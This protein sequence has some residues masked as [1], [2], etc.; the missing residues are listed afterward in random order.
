MKFSFRKVIWKILSLLPSDV[1]FSIIRSGIKIQKEQLSQYRFKIA[2]TQG[3]IEQGF[4]LLYESYLNDGMI[5]PNDSQLRITKFHVL[6][7]STMIVGLKGDEVVATVTHVLDSSF[8]LPCDKVADFSELRKPE[9]T[10][11]EVSALA[12]KK[13][14]RRQNSLLFGLTRF[15]FD[16]SYHQCGVNY[17]VICIRKRIQDYYRAVFFFKPFSKSD[18]NYSEV[19]GL[20]SVILKNELK[21]LP[22]L[23]EN[24]YKSLP[25]EKNL[26]EFYFGANRELEQNVPDFLFKTSTLPVLT[27]SML[28]YF[29][30]EKTSILSELTDSEKIEILNAYNH[31]EYEEVIELETNASHSRRTSPRRTV[32]MRGFFVVPNDFINQIINVSILCISR[33]GLL[34]YSRHGLPELDKI[35]LHVEIV[36]NQTILVRLEFIKEFK[37]GTFACRIVADDNPAWL[38]FIDAIEAHIAGFTANQGAFPV[39]K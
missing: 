24:H 20:E 5:D 7:T 31:P 34:M 13:G 19:K 10:I 39:D 21:T 3:E 9:V 11:A 36:P 37:E 12:I 22:H 35:E 38:K 1:R 15:L 14:Y 8:G 25:D 2:T 32:N 16:Y 18:F 30:N 33:G 4:R 23:F 26:Y 29:F 17:W 6:P 28:N 27:P